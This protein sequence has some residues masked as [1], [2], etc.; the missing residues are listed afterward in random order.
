MTRG[1]ARTCRT[2]ALA[3]IAAAGLGACA[4]DGDDDGDGNDPTSV[5]FGDTALV[6][7]VNPAV[8]EANDEEMPEPGPAR[9]GLELSTDDGAATVTGASGIAVLGPLEPGARTVRV[10]GDGVDASFSVELA[11]GELREI[12]LAVEGERAEVMVEID[13]R[14]EQLVELDPSMSNEA[15]NGALAV[16]DTVVFFR[17]GIYAGDLDF[18]GSRVTLFGEGLLGGEVLLDGDVLIS[19]SDSRVRGAEITGS[20]TVPASGVG[21]SFSRIDGLLSADGSD[22]TFLASEMCGGAN[23]SGSGSIV[24]GNAGAAPLIDV[25]DCP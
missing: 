13:Y 25:A 22:A 19:G 6:V 12:A 1:T 14:S 21:V 8:N 10:L 3:A 5:Q 11:A 16:S 15:V 18:S 24:L 17:G 9:A 2:V 23:I 20:L 4:G 7:V